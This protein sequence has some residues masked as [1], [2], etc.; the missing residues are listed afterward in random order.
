MLNP[1]PTTTIEAATTSVTAPPVVQH[2]RQALLWP[3]RLMPRVPNAQRGSSQHGPWQVLRDISDASPWR[4][5]IDE[6]TGDSSRFHERHYNEFVSFLPYVQR[7]LYGEGRARKHGDD[8]RGN[9]GDSPMR[10]FRRHDIAGVR[11][12][13]QPGDAPITLDVI[14]CDLYFFFDID[15]VLLNLEVG[16]NNLS[17]AQAQEIL[18]RFGRAY[19]AGWDADG[20]AL[21]C[22][23]SV[24]WLGA[25]GRVLARSDAQQRESFLSHVAQ[26]R[27]PRIAAHWAF[28]MQPLVS[29]HSEEPGVLRYRQIE[30]YR[31]PVMAYLSLDDP[32][33][34]TRN[35]FIRLG[36]V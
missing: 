4:E 33:R 14:H 24:E 26:H 23:H 32:R 5:E 19:P 31:M 11:V 3:L 25:D 27:A 36:L 7:F 28:L 30:Y 18:Y 1:T 17:L 9:E 20:G 16:V 10:I 22:M 29:D 15:V 8:E 12:V 2:L 34:M 6:Y 13:A 35:D 21:H